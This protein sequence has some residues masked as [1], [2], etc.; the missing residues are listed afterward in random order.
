ML[1]PL[2]EDFRDTSKCS[3]LAL[4]FQWLVF[5]S[6]RDD[7]T[8]QAFPFPF[9]PFLLFAWFSLLLLHQPVEFQ[10]SEHDLNLGL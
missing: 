6:F 10:Q 5:E 1:S 9:T 7:G 4:G 2:L 3:F 8:S